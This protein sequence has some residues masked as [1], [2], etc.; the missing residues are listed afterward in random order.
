MKKEQ[1]LPWGRSRAKDGCSRAARSVFFLRKIQ[2]WRRFTHPL[3][4]FGCLRWRRP[5][6]LRVAAE[7]G[8]RLTTRAKAYCQQIDL[9]TSGALTTLV[10]TQNWTKM[11]TNVT[12]VVEIAYSSIRPNKTREKQKRV[13]CLFWQLS[14]NFRYKKKLLRNFLRNFG[15]L[16]ASP[17]R[18]S[19]Q[20]RI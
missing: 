8:A 1:F 19:Y 20:W 4:W 11:L 5:Y 12:F 6:S 17:R 7:A 15:Q 13:F 18:N 2:K 3:H 9:A 10:K 16:V 14:R